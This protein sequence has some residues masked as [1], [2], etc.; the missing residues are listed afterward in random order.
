MRHCCTRPKDACSIPGWISGFSRASD[1]N[2]YKEYFFARKSDLCVVLIIL[3][4]SCR[5]CLLISAPETT[6]NLR[7]S[8]SMQRNCFAF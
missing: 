7:G 8:Q 2:E 3:P 6:G 5:N 4:V 1:R